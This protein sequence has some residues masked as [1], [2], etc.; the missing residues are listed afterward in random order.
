[1]PLLQHIIP[2]QER[3][4][5]AW[6]AESSLRYHAS[7]ISCYVAPIFIAACLPQYSLWQSFTEVYGPL[8]VVVNVQCM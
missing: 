1:M 8:I 5:Y 6:T 7:S 3:W 4:L 2:Q